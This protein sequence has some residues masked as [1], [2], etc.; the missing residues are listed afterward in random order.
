VGSSTHIQYAADAFFLSNGRFVGSASST[1]LGW[2]VGAGFDYS[3]AR[4]WTVKAEYLYISLGS[5]SYASC[6]VPCSPF[7]GVLTT[8]TG[9]SFREHVVRV[10]LNYRFSD[11]ALVRN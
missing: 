7:F 1:R 3:L 6:T 4:N 11:S 8:T 2:T 10:G 9:V 5:L